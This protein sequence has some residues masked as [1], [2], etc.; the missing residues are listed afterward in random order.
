MRHTTLS[1]SLLFLACQAQAHLDPYFSM[2]MG[3]VFPSHDIDIEGDSTYDLYG[4]TASPSG[5]SI[6]QFPNIHWKNELKTGFE[7]NLIVG[8]HLP[9]HLRLEG[10]FLYQN[11]MRDMS[12]SFDWIEYDS[13]SGATLFG[14]TPNTLAKSNSTVNVYSLLSNLGYDFKNH[15]SV[16]PFLMAGFGI[17]WINSHSVE[18]M[19]VLYSNNTTAPFG[20]PTLETS[21][22]LYGT[23]FAWQ[24]KAGL[25]F[26][27]QE[28]ISFDLVYRLFATSQFE[29]TNGDITSNPNTPVADDFF[30]PKNDV[31]GLLNNTVLLNFRYTFR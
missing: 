1:L 26:A 11:M 7:T 6:F 29:Q 19:N 12:G 10:E 15:T 2:G 13:F 22:E 8:M 18:K 20:S 25:N 28:N 3:V 27:W 30:L 9:H 21:P 16:T 4:P 24:L 17:A 14:P 5:S 31:N 23:A